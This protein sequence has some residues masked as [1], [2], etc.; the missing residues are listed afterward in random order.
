MV[1]TGFLGGRDEQRRRY[2]RRTVASAEYGGSVSTPPGTN[3]EVPS[4]VQSGVH[5]RRTDENAAEIDALAGRYGGPVGVPGV[6]AGL[7]RQATRV[8]VPGLAVAWGFT[9]DEEDGVDGGWWPQGITNSAHVPGVDRRLLVTSWYA[10]D[11]RG[12]RITAV[13]L[14]TLRYRHVLLVVPEL[15]SGG[16]RLSPLTV[17]AGGLVWAGPHLF[18]AGTRRGL[19]TCRMDDIMEVEPD[20]ESFGHRFVLPVRFA[21]DAQHDRDEMRYSFLSLDRSTEVPHLVAGEYGR[22][23]MT[24]RIVR[25]SLDPET[26]ALRSDQDGVSRPVSFDDRGLGHMQ[27]AAIVQGRYYVTTSRGRWRL[28]ALQVGQPGSFRTHRLAT[29]VGPEDLCYFDNDLL[30]SLSEYP[31]HRYVFAMERSQLE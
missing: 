29:P 3:A 15:R 18:V 30:W 7:D 23:E 25:Y 26:Y 27:G 5:L 11:D 6:L 19:F 12:S 24:R 8:P 4:E 31:G 16:V 22:D 13:D 28:G 1:L 21:Y 17:H 9:W 10:K 2:P 20:E 14:D